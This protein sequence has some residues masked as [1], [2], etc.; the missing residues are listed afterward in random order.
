MKQNKP[1]LNIAHKG[2]RAFF[3]S[4]ALTTMAV[5]LVANAA[6]DAK[7]SVFEEIVV[8]ALKRS[9][10]LQSTP[11]SISA[12]SAEK[13][14]KMGADDMID[15]IRSVPSLS[16]V[17][18]GPGQRRLVIRGVQGTGEAQVGLYYDETPV[19]GAPGAGNSPGDSQPDIKLFDV[20]RVEVLRGPQGTLYGSGSMSGTLR[21]IFTKPNTTEFEGAFDG[22]ISSTAHGGGNYE[23]NGMVNV[24]LVEDKLAARAVL[25]WRD[26]AGYIDN[27]RL[28]IKDHNS[29]DTWDG[30]FMVRFN[31]TE[32]LTI[33]ASAVLQRSN[34]NGDNKWNPAIGEL[35][36]DEFTRTPFFDDTDIF[37]VTLNWDLDFATLTGSSSYYE[38]RAE[39]N[40][41]TTK[42]ISTFDNNAVCAIQNGQSPA[43][44]TCARRSNRPY[45]LY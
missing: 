3:L 6:D 24:P 10:T 36:I 29:Q 31:A 37:N 42:F 34:I 1:Y 11:I 33:D 19:T 28:G 38:R 21:V 22:T 5:P 40:F 8:T 18:G 39:V 43:T 7:G 35:Q 26:E 16:L 4:T 30:R 45:Q 17:D 23:L 12:V 20:E 27:V 41:D 14:E 15:Y 9:S 2:L 25:F 13:L 44:Y 32:N